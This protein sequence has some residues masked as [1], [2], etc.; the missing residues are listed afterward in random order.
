MTICLEHDSF[1]AV[2]ADVRR[3]AADLAETRARAARE[4][5]GLL[6]GDWTG[7]AASSFGRGWSEW[8]AGAADV[9]AALEGMAEAMVLA[10]SRLVVADDSG[11][12]S[13]ARLAA[14]LG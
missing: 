1:D 3:A 6:D 2:L 7:A 5:E 12:G 13:M 8:A 9:E 11:A 10:R 14:R 4:V